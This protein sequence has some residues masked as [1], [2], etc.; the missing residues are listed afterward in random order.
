LGPGRRGSIAIRRTGAA[1]TA[2]LQGYLDVL[3][4]IGEILPGSGT[5]VA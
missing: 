2:A 5:I 1:P 4:E 3:A